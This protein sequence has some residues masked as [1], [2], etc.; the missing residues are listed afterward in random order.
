MSTCHRS[1]TRGHRG[2]RLAFK[3]VAVGDRSRDGPRR[4][5]R[6]RP[7]RPGDAHPEP[8]R[9]PDRFQLAA[10][11]EPSET[12]RDG[13]GR[14]LRH[15]RPAR[16]LPRF[17]RCRR[18]R[19]GPDR[20]A[21]R[22]ACRGGAGGARRRAPRLRREADVH[23]ACRRRR[24]RR[25]TRPRGTR[26]AGRNDEALRP[27]RRA[28]A[29]GAAR[30][31]SRP[32]LRERRRQRPRVRP[33]LRAGR[34]RARHRR[35]AGCDR[36]RPARRRRRRSR[37]RS[38]RATR[39][40][41]A[42]SRRASSAA[43]CTTSTSCTACSSGWA[44]LCRREVVAGD[45]WNE[46]RAV[47][48]SLRLANGARCDSAWIG[49][50]DTFEYHETISFLFADSVRDA[51]LSPRRGCGSTRPS[52]AGVSG[53]TRRTRSARSRPTPSRSRASWST[54]TTAS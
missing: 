28:H 27:G 13:A 20:V 33:L 54:S 9:T 23:H 43:S 39:T 3:K 10:L 35:P 42:R 30:L 11:A 1:A 48:G 50:H 40:S 22:D 17:A 41:C 44:S 24:D 52:I 15:R 46:G 16:R 12:V 32:P 19:R 21:R 25:R 53:R 51:Q 7:R 5:R 18:S 14:A 47:T 4:R 2:D 26:R 49:L 29:R 36:R 37:R 45:W 31:G 6:G 8:R 38:A 34:H